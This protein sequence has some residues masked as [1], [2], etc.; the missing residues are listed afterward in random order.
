MQGPRRRLAKQYS[1][2]SYK[3]ELFSKA[4]VTK[5]YLSA[6]RWLRHRW[7]SV[8]KFAGAGSQTAAAAGWMRKLWQFQDDSADNIELQSLVGR[9]AGPSKAK[10]S[11]PSPAAAHTG[12][13]SGFKAS[14]AKRGVM[15]ARAATKVKD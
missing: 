4:A 13:G 5:T 2:Q 14:H 1:R 15:H 8:S 7:H 9:P 6:K 12:D 11:M 3:A 10:L